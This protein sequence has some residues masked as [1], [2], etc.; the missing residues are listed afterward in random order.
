L[1]TLSATEAQE[2]PSGPD[3]L[4]R[5][6]LAQAHR[7]GEARLI[8]ALALLQE[9]DV[10]IKLGELDPEDALHLFILRWVPV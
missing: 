9:L 10:R 4:I 8:Q 1:L 7:H 3:W 5:R 6:R 2:N